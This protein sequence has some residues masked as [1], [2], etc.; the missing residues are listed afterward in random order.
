S[1]LVVVDLDVPKNVDD[2]PPANTPAGVTDGASALA[3]LAENHGE[4]YPSATYTIRTATGGTH[5]YFTAPT[6]PELRNTAGALGWKI[7]TRAHGGYV[8]GAGSTIDGNRYTV[9]DDT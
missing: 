5:L 6:G 3:A 4:P 2:V 8:V 1:R 7:D 9:V